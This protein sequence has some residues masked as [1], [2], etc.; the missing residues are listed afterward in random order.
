MD[1]KA[2]SKEIRGKVWPLLKE[3]G[4]SRFTTRTA[5]R[6]CDSKIDVLNFQ[7]FNAYNASVMR[8]TPFSFAVNLGSFLTYVPPDWPLQS[9]DGQLT[10]RE[11]DCQFRGR[12]IPTVT[13]S[14]KTPDGV[15]SVDELG[16]NLPRCIQD[17]VEQL[18]HAMDWFARLADKREVLRVLCEDDEDMIVLWGF[19]RNPSPIRSYLT[20]YVA[21]ELENH[22]L[23]REKLGEAV[24]SDCF[25]GQFGNLKNAI[26]RAP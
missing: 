23:A 4:F 13:Q 11:A 3:Q 19:G 6:Y 22:D 17:V 2:V 14:R 1:S 25:T 20:G 26:N 9:T 12:L 10:P 15:W 7:S 21:L 18:P 24:D 5:W 8:V 16:R